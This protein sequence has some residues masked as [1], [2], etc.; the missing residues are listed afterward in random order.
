MARIIQTQIQDSVE[1][2]KQKV[3]LV[4]SRITLIHP[5]RDHLNS[6]PRG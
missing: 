5:T 2:K 4:M 1:G 6:P 3:A